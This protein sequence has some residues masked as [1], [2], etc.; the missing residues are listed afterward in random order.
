MHDETLDALVE[1]LMPIVFGPPN[2]RLDGAPQADQA[3]EASG[4]HE[5]SVST[6][7]GLNSPG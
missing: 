5:S 2:R 4:H 1:A 6:L 7:E 3:A